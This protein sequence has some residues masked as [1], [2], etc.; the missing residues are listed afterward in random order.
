MDECL[1]TIHTHTQQ[2]DTHTKIQG[3]E[4]GKES[5]TERRERSRLSLHTEVYYCGKGIVMTNQR[6]LHHF[7]VT[8]YFFFFFCKEGDMVHWRKVKDRSDA[9]IM[10]RKERVK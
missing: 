3:E 1:L 6:P 8:F 7:T 10:E 2:S 9:T 4:Q 5:Q